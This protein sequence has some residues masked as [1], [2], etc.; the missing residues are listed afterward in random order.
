[1]KK[2]KYFFKKIK[3]FFQRLFRGYSDC[4]IWGL[5]YHLS[6]LIIKRLKA[7]RD[8]DKQGL[9]VQFMDEFNLRNGVE[10]EVER[11]LE[12]LNGFINDMIWSFQYCLNDYK[13]EETTYRINLFSKDD[14]TWK[15]KEF[16]DNYTKYLYGMELFTKY[17]HCLWD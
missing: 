5:D 17:F 10:G 13:E 8:L 12:I 4:D 2:V 9:S 6:H 7:F 16:D 11:G 14:N 15:L 3:W 1:M